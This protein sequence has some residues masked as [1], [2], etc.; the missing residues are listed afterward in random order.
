M[1]YELGALRL[2]DVIA[3]GGEG[4][5][6]ALPAM[7]GHAAK[8]YHENA[9][10][11]H[12]ARKIEF[13]TGKRVAGQLANS[14]A[15]PED[16][17]VDQGRTVGFTMARFKARP[18]DELLSNDACFKTDWK[19]RVRAAQRLSMVV[20][21]LHDAGIVI[22]DLHPSNF[23][24]LP[25]GD[26]V[27]YD[28]DSV[29]VRDGARLF[30]TTVAHDDA[31]PPELAGVDLAATPGAL[32]QE[33]DDY[34]LA[35][36]VFRVLMGCHPFAGVRTASAASSCSGSLSKAV[37]DAD[38]VF[39]KN[40]KAAPRYAAPYETVG[41][42]RPLFRKAFVEG[43]KDPFRRPTAV[44]FAQ[45]LSGLLAE[46]TSRCP[47]HGSYPSRLGKC[48]FCS[49][50]QVEAPAPLPVALAPQAKAPAAPATANAAQAAGNVGGGNGA[51]ASGAETALA[52]LKV[53]GCVALVMLAI[54]VIA[55]I[56]ANIQYILGA[57]F[58]I[59]FCWAL[60]SAAD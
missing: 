34:M 36:A 5:L 48:P 16:A 52:V 6:Y 12:R 15:W 46:Q 25:D 21:G 41:G 32:T 10:T 40:P 14:V 43:S 33:T 27:M 31:R 55:I 8:I 47:V 19:V 37:M 42:L 11:E 60:I 57:I 22:G 3:K 58:V 30:P 9:R 29:Q 39:E 54:A 20:A 35:C 28:L 38:F 1:P 51:S 44:E 56:V 18:L 45:A 53:L 4:T 50:Q 24:F 26:V 59:A 13:M 23:G 17:I 49:V 7:P 2:T